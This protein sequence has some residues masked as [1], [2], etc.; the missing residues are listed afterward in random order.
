MRWGMARPGGGSEDGWFRLG[1]IEVTTTVLVIVLSVASVVEWAF[2][3]NFG[4][5]QSHISLVPDDVVSGQVWQLLTWP[6]AYPFGIGL[7]GILAIAFFW[8][9]GTEIESLLGKKRMAW[10]LGL[11]AVGLGLLWVG[12]VELTSIS[13]GVLSGAFQLN[14]LNQLEL[15]VLLVFIAEYPQRRFFFNIPGWVIGAVIIAIYVLGYVGNR[16][17][18]YLLNFLLGLLLT[19]LVA[20]SMGLM[21]EWRGVPRVSIHRN[22]KPKRQR[23]S[24]GPTVVQGPWQPPQSP[25]VSRDQAALDALL[26][27]ISAGGMESLTDGE[28][29]QLMILRDR[30]RRR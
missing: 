14:G 5:L 21:S 19:A 18:L 16:Q 8:Y 15:M 13:N 27:K 17:W 20:K 12:F 7:F 23:R 24:T 26:D 25:P 22:P 3:G 4:P 29:E 28:R 9:F 30:L 2:E 10:F 11:I 6:L 1:S